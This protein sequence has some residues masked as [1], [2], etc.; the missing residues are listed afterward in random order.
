MGFVNGRQ[1]YEDELIMGMT[2]RECRSALLMPANAVE[3]L[4][5]D[6]DQDGDIGLNAVQVAIAEDAARPAI[7]VVLAQTRGIAVPA[8]A[9]KLPREA[10]SSQTLRFP[11]QTSVRAPGPDQQPGPAGHHR[12]ALGLLQAL[13]EPGC[14]LAAVARRR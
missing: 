6:N 7:R 1:V 11:S 2:E 13:P 4:T 14:V 5:G 9:W 3:S 10:T 12:L 8:P